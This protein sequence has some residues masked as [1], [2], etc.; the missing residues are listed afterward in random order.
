MRRTTRYLAQ[1]TIAI[2]PL[3]TL[4]GCN[5]ADQGVYYFEEP[6][7]PIHTLLQPP[8][9]PSCRAAA[10]IPAPERKTSDKP[11]HTATITEKATPQRNP[12]APGRAASEIPADVAETSGESEEPGAK[13]AQQAASPDAPPQKAKAS[14]SDIPTPPDAESPKAPATTITDLQPESEPDYPRQIRKL[15]QERDCY[16]TA[17]RHTRRKLEQLQLETARMIKARE[18]ERQFNLSY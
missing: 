2:A 5:P 12:L 18:R 1:I 3:V 13:S 17:E 10:D 7:S 6:A 15:R 8:A 4:V 11:A 9:K 16:R 14:I